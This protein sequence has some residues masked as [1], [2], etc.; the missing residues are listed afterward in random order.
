VLG[1]LGCV[2]GQYNDHE[3]TVKARSGPLAPQLTAAVEPSPAR[4]SGPG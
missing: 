1:E 4:Q 2:N 3:L